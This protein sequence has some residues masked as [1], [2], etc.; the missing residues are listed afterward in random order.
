MRQ[1]KPTAKKNK[2]PPGAPSDQTDGAL[3]GLFFCV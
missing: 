1:E 3:G 2:A